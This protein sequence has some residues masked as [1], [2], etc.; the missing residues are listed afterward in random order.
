MEKKLTTN[1]DLGVNFFLVGRVTANQQ[2]FT[3]GYSSCQLNF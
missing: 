3:D 1:F 2:F